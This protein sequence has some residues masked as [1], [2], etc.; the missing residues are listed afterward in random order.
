MNYKEKIWYWIAKKL[1]K[2][3]IYFVVI[4]VS[5]ET[6]TGKYGNTIVPKLTLFDALDRFAK[7]NN[8]N[9]YV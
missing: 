9:E 1:P 8:I 2:R 7:D 5:A 4:Y 3:L 6:T